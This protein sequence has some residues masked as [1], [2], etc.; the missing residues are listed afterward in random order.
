[1][2]FLSYLLG[3]KNSAGWDLVD[4]YRNLMLQKES[5]DIPK[6]DRKGNKISNIARF[7]ISGTTH[8]HLNSNP[9]KEI[10]RL[11]PGDLLVLAPQPENEHD[12]EA[13]RVLT[14]SGKQIG[15]IPKAY[16]E[17]SLIFRRLMEQYE[18]F[19]CVYDRGVS[20]GGFPWCEITV[21]TYGTPFDPSVDIKFPNSYLTSLL[22][23][24]GR[25]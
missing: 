21:V 17:K 20:R 22:A 4:E 1:M 18:I 9:K 16:E 12:H 13:V 10:A 6:T 23:M 19:C 3:G 11:S 15:W 14:Y 5:N 7:N 2:S 25:L 24:Q 8:S